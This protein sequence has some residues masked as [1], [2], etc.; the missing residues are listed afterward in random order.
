VPI[1]Y[2]QFDK[3]KRVDDEWTKQIL[4]NRLE[5]A[6]TIHVTLLFTIFLVVS[7]FDSIFCPVENS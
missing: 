3:L 1:N 5:N 2:S 6:Q 4:L 7:R